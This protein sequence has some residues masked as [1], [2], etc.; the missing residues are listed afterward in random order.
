MTKKEIAKRMDN[1]RLQRQYWELVEAQHP[2]TVRDLDKEIAGLRAR[3]FHL[4]GQMNEAPGKL[5]QADRQMEYLQS[6]NFDTVVQPKVN[7]VKKL[8]MELARLESELADSELTPE[9]LALIKA[10]L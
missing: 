5:A 7:R 8:Q 1:V 4:Q 2:K 10:A 9:Q 6:Q 3:Q